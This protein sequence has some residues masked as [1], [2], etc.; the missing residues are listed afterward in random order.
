MF[1]VGM[2]T[3]ISDFETTILYSDVIMFSPTMDHFEL[4]LLYRTC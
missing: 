1:P 3:Y 2:V 4:A